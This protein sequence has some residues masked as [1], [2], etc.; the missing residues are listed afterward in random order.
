MQN[1]KPY[2]KFFQLTPKYSKGSTKLEN[3]HHT[4]EWE[5][6]DHQWRPHSRLVGEDLNLQ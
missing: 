5:P 2:L 4:P 1:I 3:N 6:A